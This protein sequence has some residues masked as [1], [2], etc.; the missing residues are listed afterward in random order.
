MYNLERLQPCIYT[1]STV[2][3]QGLLLLKKPTD[4]VPIPFRRHQYSFEQEPILFSIGFPS[5]PDLIMFCM[6]HG[7][8]YEKG[9]L[10]HFQ[11][12]NQNMRAK[13]DNRCRARD[14]KEYI[15]I[16]FMI[17]EDEVYALSTMNLCLSDDRRYIHLTF[18][19]TWSDVVEPYS[20]THLKRFL[21]AQEVQ[22]KRSLRNSDI[23]TPQERLRGYKLG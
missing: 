13:V 1:N 3:S 2:K 8:A 23:H 15:G 19:E 16:S 4:K 14:L 21:K 12:F 22:Q 6:D 10:F 20:R 5:L 9:A 18:P 11:D 7:Y 17:F